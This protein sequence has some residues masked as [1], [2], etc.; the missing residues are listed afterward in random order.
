MLRQVAVHYSEL[1]EKI[2]KLEEKYDGNFNK[3][4]EALQHLLLKKE[5]EE[6]F[7]NRPCIGFR[8]E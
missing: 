4:F 2:R 5:Q 1:E 6:A 3:V 8:K 7:K